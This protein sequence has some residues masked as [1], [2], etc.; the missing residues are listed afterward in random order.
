MPVK[1][2]GWMADAYLCIGLSKI[3]FNLFEW[4]TCSTVLRIYFGGALNSRIMGKDIGTI[5]CWALGFF[6][7]SGCGKTHDYGSLTDIDGNT[8]KT[9]VIGNQEWMAEN[10]NVA[11]YSNGDPIPNIPDNPGWLSDTL[12]TWCY[13]DNDPANGEVFGKLYNGYAMLDSRGICPNGW[14]IPTDAEWSELEIYLGMPVT[15]AGVIGDG[16]GMLENL[17]GALADD[18]LGLWGSPSTWEVT[19]ASGFSALPGGVRATNAAFMLLYGTAAF[20]CSTSAGDTAAFVR[21]I[22]KMYPGVSRHAGPYVMG[23]SC[24]CVKD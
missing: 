7:L 20:W 21:D 14:H 18:E 10:L 23:C 12:G 6:L 13:Y 3:L 8:Y 24:R 5:G 22:Y 2:L 16:R 9:I 11:H 4:K 17:G 15:H 1:T 19:N